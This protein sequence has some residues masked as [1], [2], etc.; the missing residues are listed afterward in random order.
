MKKIIFGVLAGA[1]FLLLLVFP[2]LCFDAA[3]AGLLLW[4]ETLVPSLFPV[5][6]LSNLLIATNVAFVCIQYI[7]RPFTALLGLTPYGVYAMFVG[8]FCGC[9][10]GAKVL[11]DLRRNRQIS[12]EEAV[13]L[14][15][16]CNN[17]SP[18]FLINF[19]VVGHLKSEDFIGPTLCILMGAPVLFGLFSNHRYRTLL[20]S[21]SQAKIKNKP[22]STAITFAMADACI[23]DSIYN[24][25]KLG[26]YVILFFVLT[27][28]LDF[29]PGSTG[30]AKAILSGITEISG[31]IHHIACLP[32]TFPQ[33][34]ILLTAAASFGGLCCA[35]QS[36]GMLADIGMPL[37]HYLLSKLGITAIAVIMAL[38]YIS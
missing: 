23:S 21:H 2:K 29:L 37:G 3:K 27:A 31:G 16:F 18:A 7:S 35:A 32:L 14:A 17:L 4:F 11:S 12:Q 26:G 19:L 10:M 5:M 24:M 25:T 34:Y 22:S 20:G 13:Y 28:F 30:L 1:S 36:A 8:F 33:K 15:G 6:I 38:C 9:P